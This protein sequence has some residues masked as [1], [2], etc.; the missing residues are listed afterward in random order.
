MLS[1]ESQEVYQKDRP[2]TV[3]SLMRHAHQ[4]GTSRWEDETLCFASVFDLQ[5]APLAALP[6]HRRMEKFLRE[7]GRL[8]AHI[9]FGT[10]PLLEQPGTRWAPSTFLVK[11]E[12]PDNL[13]NRDGYYGE[14]PDFMETP[15][16]VTTLG[17]YDLTQYARRSRQWAL[18]KFVG[19]R[20]AL[21]SICSTASPGD[22]PKQ[23]SD[24]GYMPEDFPPSLKLIVLRKDL[25]GEA[26]WVQSIDKRVGTEKVKY[27][28]RF[29]VLKELGQENNAMDDFWSTWTGPKT[30]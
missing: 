20:K 27:I 1:V 17:G 26:I 2:I 25:T 14:V 8:P 19:P 21:Y 6:G 7:I 9:L 18:L 24:L 5:T 12:F 23:D 22:H 11:H 30:K 16:F 29:D 13:E 3:L 4:L 28:A 10:G 15:G